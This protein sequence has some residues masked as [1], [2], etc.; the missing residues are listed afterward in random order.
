MFPLAEVPPADS[1]LA[2]SIHTKGVWQLCG[3]LPQ[4]TAKLSR[5][6]AR[7]RTELPPRSMA[8]IVFHLSRAR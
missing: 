7:C 6:Q 2:L 8:P 1:T 5:R 4:P 3:L